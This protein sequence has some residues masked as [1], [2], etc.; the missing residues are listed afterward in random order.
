MA[1]KILK[2]LKITM[3]MMTTRRGENSTS[4][5][6]EVHTVAV[7]KNS[8][9]WDLNTAL[10]PRRQNTF[11]ST[12]VHFVGRSQKSTDCICRGTMLQ[13]ARSRVRVPMSSL[14]FLNLPNPSSHTMSLGSTR[15]LTEMSTRNL[16]AGKG[17][18]NCKADDNFN[19]S[20]E[21]IV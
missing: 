21:P 2:K 8:V 4:V 17:R 12:V 16:L 19:T 13:A 6:F 14:N 3:K 11:S 20:C 5:G 9:F 10:Y 15:P 1:A 18:P 7:M